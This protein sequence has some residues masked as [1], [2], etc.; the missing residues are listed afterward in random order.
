MHSPR[1]THRWTH[2]HTRAHTHKH[3]PTHTLSG[4]CNHTRTCAHTCTCLPACVRAHVC[5]FVC[6]RA[7]RVCGCGFESVRPALSV[8]ACAGE[9]A[10]AR[11]RAL[12]VVRQRPCGCVGSMRV[13]VRVCAR[14]CVRAQVRVCARALAHAR[15]CAFVC[16]C[17]C[18]FAVPS[19]SI[20][21]R[22]CAWVP[23]RARLG[24]VWALWGH[25][26]LIARPAAGGARAVADRCDRL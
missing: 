20:F 25:A 15:A 6:V 3:T 16:A 5:D 1:H 18:G 12:A 10:C 19:A 11:R 7:T 21:A 23:A 2:L 14:I 22:V 9:A 13:C 24:A 26:V 8:C 4:E 17:E